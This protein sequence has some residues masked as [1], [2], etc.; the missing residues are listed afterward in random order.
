MPRLLA[1]LDAP[2]SGMNATLRECPAGIGH[3]WSVPDAAG[4]R[5][6]AFCRDRVHDPASKPCDTCKGGTDTG[7]EDPVV[8]AMGGYHCLSCDGTG[9]IGTPPWEDPA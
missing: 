7:M 2:G 5:E 8:R 3:F 9:V 6:C 4:W 1:S